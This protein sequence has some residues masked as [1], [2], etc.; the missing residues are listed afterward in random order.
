[1]ATE[2]EYNVKPVAA[3]H[4]TVAIVGRPNVGKSALFNRI[5]GR[6]MAIVH[7]QSGVTRDRV[8]AL[9]DYR[10]CRFTL[11]DTG[12]LGLFND[13]KQGSSAWDVLI[14]EQLHV[15]LESANKIGRAHV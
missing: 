3:K 1:M 9:A 4:Q 11:V 15:A 7:H 13:Q 12:G 6:K 14:R 5:V 8:A 2:S 10:D